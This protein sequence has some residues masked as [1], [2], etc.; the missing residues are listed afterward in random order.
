[1]FFLF[2]LGLRTVHSVIQ[3]Q[4]HLTYNSFKHLQITYLKVS[5][6]ATEI[7]TPLSSPCHSPAADMYM[8]NQLCYNFSA[9]PSVILISTTLHLTF[10]FLPLLGVS[11]L[12]VWQ[13]SNVLL[14]REAGALL[15]CTKLLLCTKGFNL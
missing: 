11:L 5:Y 13:L 1:M 9:S 10:T 4:I 6:W 14:Q 15:C 2:V 12:A 7:V 3:D 8:L